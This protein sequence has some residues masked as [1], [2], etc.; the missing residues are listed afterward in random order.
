MFVDSEM[1]DFDF[2]N[3]LSENIEKNFYDSQ[4][5]N[6]TKILKVIFSEKFRDK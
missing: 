2:M 6:F 4:S 3:L 1:I 5:E